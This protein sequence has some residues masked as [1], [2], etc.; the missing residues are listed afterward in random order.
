MRV[1]FIPWIAFAV[2]VVGSGEVARPSEPVET[3]TGDIVLAP[4]SQAASLESHSGAITLQRDAH[5][6]GNVK[7]YSGAIRIEGAH[8]G[9]RIDTTDS[10]IYIGA[11]SRIDGGIL[12]HRRSVAGLNLGEDF[13]IGIPVGRSTPPRVVIGARATVA[14]VLR[15]N[16]QVE[17]RVS[18]S[19]KIGPI[20][21]ATPVMFA[22]EEPPP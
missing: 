17:L 19:A 9:G 21:G 10:D 12:V 22:T 20:E 7:S 8:V 3:F 16:R 18:E 6:A 5:V 11:D 1:G 14:G 13:A 4:H 15:F 2:V